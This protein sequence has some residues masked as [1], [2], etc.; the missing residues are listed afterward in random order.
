[1]ES[2]GS[3]YL[4]ENIGGFKNGEITMIYGPH[5][6]GKTTICLLIS[7]LLSTLGK[8]VIYIDTE[9]SF[10]VERI[11][12]LHK[13]NCMEALKNILILKADDFDKQHIFTKKLLKENFDLLVIDSLTNNYRQCDKKID[14]N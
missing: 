1:M 7:S 14:A 5:A 11:A 13:E 6:S 12:Q 10:S 2:T 3:K 9:K 4:D 8:K